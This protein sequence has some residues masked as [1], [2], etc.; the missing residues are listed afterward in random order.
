[1]SEGADSSGTPA[2]SGARYVAIIADG[3]RRWARARGLSAS[4]GHD[5]GAQTL[6]A[7]VRD[8]AELGVEE[9]TVYSFSTENWARPSA[10]VRD[11]VSML[12]RRIAAETPKL[13]E[14]GVQ[15]RYIGR[16]E[17]I[18]RELLERLEWSESLTRANEGMTLCV[19]FNYGGRAE[20][21]DAARKYAGTTEAEFRRGLY[22]P[23]LHDPEVI[24]RT[25]G[26]QRLSNFLLWQ[27]AYAELVFRAELWPDFTR[28]DLERSL[29]EYGARKRRFGGRA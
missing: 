14:Q 17:G 12:A 15:V 25:G 6:K 18:A 22:A 3:N 26:E 19:A 5:A 7:R 21:L 13:H 29:G 1:M 10:E 9:L 4:A 11:L 28:A 16:R 20:M 23:D 24:I 27:S 8:A 2:R